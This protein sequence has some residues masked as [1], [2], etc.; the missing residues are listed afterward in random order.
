MNVKDFIPPILI[1]LIKMVF[2]S[3]NSIEVK[4][5][6]SYNE[7]LTECTRY[8]YENEELCHMVAD[9]TRVYFEELK[10]N[11]PH[12]NYANAFLLYAI[13]QTFDNSN[14][15]VSLL[16]FGGA[17]GT[18]Y[19]STRKF[20]PPDLRFKWIVIEAKRMVQAAKLKKLS[21][22][23]LFFM[24]NINKVIESDSKIDL[25]YTS[26]AIQYVDEPYDCLKKLLKVGATYIL[27]E[28]MILGF[29]DND[30]ISIQK[31]L[32][33]ANGPGRLPDGYQDKFVAYPRTVMSYQKF[34]NVVVDSYDLMWTFSDND[35]VFRIKEGNEFKGGMLFRKK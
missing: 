29:S 11:T 32:L 30:V 8:G 25:V 19:F 35:E 34:I 12:L 21:G 17:C 14:G 28:R 31:S 4:F 5:Y 2:S 33:S 20:L 15:S 13:G 24:D 7:A 1:R 23:E 6:N 3:Q 22:N 16:D 10:K 26:G 27:F 18:H 9:K